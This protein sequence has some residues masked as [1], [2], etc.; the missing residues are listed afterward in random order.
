L[1]S[2]FPKIA[3]RLRMDGIEVADP[4]VERLLE[5]FAFLARRIQLKLDAEFPRFT[6]RLLE[7]VYPNYL[8][9]TPSMLVAQVQPALGTPALATGIQLPRGSELRSGPIRGTHTECRFRTATAWSCGR[10]R[11]PA[12]PTSRMPPT[13]RWPPARIAQV[14]VAACASACAPPPGSTFAH[15]AGSAPLLQ[16]Q[17]RDGLQ[18]ARAGVRQHAGR[19]GAA[20]RRHAGPA[21]MSGATAVRAVGFDDDQALLPVRRCP[22]LQ[23]T[24][25]CRSTSPSRSASCSSISSAWARPCV[26]S[27][28]RGRDRAA[29]RPRRH[30]PAAGGG[31]AVAGLHCVPAINLFEQRCDRIQVSPRTHDFHVVVDRARPMD[32]EVIELLEVR[33]LRS[34]PGQRTRFKPLYAAFH[35]RTT[36]HDAYYA[37]QREPRLLSEKQR[38]EGPRSSYIGSRG[39]HH[40]RRCLGGAL[41]RHA[42]ATGARALCSNRD[43]PLLMA[44]RRWRAAPGA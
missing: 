18:A 10:W 7:I 34:G 22:G 16:R 27:V 9:P 38:R 1:P 20:D 13:C 29:V 44:D 26:R 3:A 40:R 35:T 24:G 33:R 5:G 4:Y 19:A 23:A 43:L 30:Q 37:T 2:S 21:A 36:D 8:A 28:G 32:F 11:S 15:P 17:R 25:C 31:R 42:A 39:L 14:R 12:S 41:S 6:E